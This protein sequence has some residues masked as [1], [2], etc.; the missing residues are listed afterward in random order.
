MAGKQILGIF[1]FLAAIVLAGCTGGPHAATATASDATPD[2]APAKQNVPQP[3]L[4]WVVKDTYDPSTTKTG[5]TVTLG[6]SFYGDT[7]PADVATA[8]ALSALGSALGEGDTQELPYIGAICDGGHWGGGKGAYAAYVNFLTPLRRGESG[9]STSF[10]ASLDGHPLPSNEFTPYSEGVPW[11]T[12]T[13]FLVL[14]T[15]NSTGRTP[16]GG[17]LSI[18]GTTMAGGSVVAQ[19]TLPKDTA[20]IL[21]KAC[22]LHLPL[23]TNQGR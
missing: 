17:K 1:V 14:L 21:D 15:G 19:F 13:R 2:A 3:Q 4:D 5:R 8:N 22:G 10:T 20:V 7:E 16:V 6:G 18:G 11:L 12:Q 23:K 9:K